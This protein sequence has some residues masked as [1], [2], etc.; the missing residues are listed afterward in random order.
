MEAA[1]EGPA[2]NIGGG[3]GRFVPTTGTEHGEPARSTSGGTTAPMAEEETG[4]MHRTEVKGLSSG[5]S[6]ASSG[7]AK[8]MRPIL[9]Y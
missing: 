2:K 3:A 9:A 6:C 7:L 4:E 8:F 1:H 5:P